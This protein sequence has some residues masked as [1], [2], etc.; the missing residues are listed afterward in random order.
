[1]TDHAARP[2]ELSDIERCFGGAI[3]AVMCTLA[4]DGTPNVTYLSRAHRVDDDRV[5]LSNQFMSKTAKN[6]AV[7]PHASLILCDPVFY[8]DFRLSLTYERTER[9][10]HVFDR[11]KADIDTLAA[12]QG[13]QDVFRLRAADIFRVDSIVRVN[14]EPFTTTIYEERPD[15]G[16]G[17]LAE[18]ATRLGRSSD[19]DVVVDTALD[20]IV[21]LLG[22]HHVSLLLLDE[23]GRRL[24]TIASRGFEAERV[25]AEVEMGSGLI[26]LVGER[27]APIR[28]AS[29]HQMAKYSRSI[30]R[31]FEDD[32]GMGPGR[33]IP[34]PGLEQA[35]SRLAVPAMA[36]GQLVGVL[37]VDRLAP[38][39]FDED[40]EHV[41]V[42]VASMLATAIELAR[43]TER[44]AE[45]AS[46][47]VPAS[48]TPPGGS[49]TTARFFEVDGSL[50]LDGDYLIKGVAGRILWSLAR[51]HVAD[52]RVDFTN[53]ELRLDPSL[54]LPDFKDNLES[55]L[56]L[57]KRRL[58]ERAAPIRMERTGRGRFRLVVDGTI[59]LQQVDA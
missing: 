8:N 45:P 16:I 46:T 43:V 21:D 3:P 59:D 48:T 53:R 25:G 54:Q 9:R 47:A 19:L 41:L 26:G 34:I 2:L 6:L 42:A 23:A 58:D 33:E 37:S 44:D 1:M 15:V 57:L 5:A 20:S 51:Q 7:N 22:Y 40:D 30:R 17:A 56:V 32:A 29:L 10:G 27:C 49:V 50:F 13:M 35:E 38:S 31:S 36:L 12:L 18:L 11:L 39:A 28:V 24:Y 52:G 4:A 14:P 55:R